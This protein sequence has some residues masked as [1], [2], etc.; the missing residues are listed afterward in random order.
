MVK[1]KAATIREWAIIK[2]QC[3]IFKR[4][5]S[6]KNHNHAKH[7]F[8]LVNTNIMLQIIVMLMYIAID[9]DQ[10]NIKNR[11]NSINTRLTYV[12]VIHIII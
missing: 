9:N 3:S 8:Q 12:L 6:S 5:K 4:F 7:G 1:I 10:S 2:R 11:L